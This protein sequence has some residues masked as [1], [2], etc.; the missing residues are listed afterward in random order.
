MSRP[1]PPKTSTS[2]SSVDPGSEKASVSGSESRIDNAIQRA[3][4][5]DANRDSNPFQYPF[6]PQSSIDSSGTTAR[7]E[8]G[9][10]K[11]Y[12]RQAYAEDKMGSRS[13]VGGG[14]ISKPRR[15]NLPEGIPEMNG[16]NGAMGRGD[17]ATPPTRSTWVRGGGEDTARGVWG[18][19]GRG[20]A[21]S[22]VSSGISEADGEAGESD[23]GRGMM[24]LQT[25]DQKS[26][27]STVDTVHVGVSTPA[28]EWVSV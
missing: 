11:Q 26:I 18:T 3:M 2:Y 17:R 27:G 15:G 23:F 14:G 19:G 1:S 12:H 22:D 21:P 5:I 4:E 8:I 25:R 13:V 20:M 9:T 10:Y 28:P 6:T 16:D 7:N 24:T